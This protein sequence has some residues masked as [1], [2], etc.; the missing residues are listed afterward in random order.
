MKIRR[1]RTSD[2]PSENSDHTWLTAGL[3]VMNSFD[4]RWGSEYPEEEITFQS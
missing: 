4:C 1:T 3:P 2:L